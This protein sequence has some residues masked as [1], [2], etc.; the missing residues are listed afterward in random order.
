MLFV[1]YWTQLVN[2]L[3]VRYYLDKF[4]ESNQTF[5][6]V[7][8]RTE[9]CSDRDGPLEPFVLPAPGQPELARL[10]CG[11]HLPPGPT[12][13]DPEAEASTGQFTRV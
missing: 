4:S 1:C 10:T 3:V 9:M 5:V 6:G 7:S 12:C 13:A 2:S 11:A 8:F